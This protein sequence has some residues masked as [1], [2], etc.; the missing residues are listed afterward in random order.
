MGLKVPPI[1]G[2]YS[3]TVSFYVLLIAVIFMLWAIRRILNSDLGTSFRAVQNDEVAA[4]SVGIPVVRVRVMGFVI[5]SAMAG[6][7]GSLVRS[8]SHVDNTAH[9]IPGFDVP[10]LG[11]DCHRRHGDFCRPDYRSTVSRRAFGIHSGLRR[12]PYL[13]FWASSACGS[14]FCAGR[15]GRPVAEV[16]SRVGV[17]GMSLLVVKEVSKR[18]GGLRAVVNVS[19]HIEEEEIV[20][21]IGP[22]GAGKT[23]LFNLVAGAIPLNE[24]SISFNGR[25]IAGLSPHVICRSG[26]ARTFQVTRPFLSM[27]C[28][29]NVLVA[30]IGRN[31]TPQANHR[32]RLV[33]EALSLVG[34]SEKETALAKDLNLIDKKRLEL[35]RALATNPRMILLDEVLGGL[36]SLEMSQA[37][38]LIRTIRDRL[39]ITVLW[40]E[41]VMGAVMLLCER[42]L[43]LDQGVLICEGSPE[44]VSNDPRVI[45]AY[46]G[47]ADAQ[48]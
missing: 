32:Q 41:H 35:A 22:N 28:A 20:G 30:L 48:D 34:L 45:K 9:S 5:T 7:A 2:E 33:R 21:L 3:K 6:L 31:E 18:F 36:S 14:T 24:G 16:D 38:D 27:T 40:I 42:L 17:C 25:Q 13:D 46:L 1:F 4:A 23:T 8:L 29:E 10:R 26:I 43:V 15:P 44:T 47:E 37:L 39:K 12:I 11:H 19:F